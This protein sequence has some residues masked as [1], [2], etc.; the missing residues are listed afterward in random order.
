MQV[1]LLYAAEINVYEI[2]KDLKEARAFV[3][4]EGMQK[5]N[6]INEKTLYIAIEN[7][8]RCALL[9]INTAMI[10]LNPYRPNVTL[11]VNLTALFSKAFAFLRT[12]K[13]DLSVVEFCQLMEQLLK[14]SGLNSLMSKGYQFL[15]FKIVNEKLHAYRRV[16]DAS[17][18]AKEESKITMNFYL[19]YVESIFSVRD[20]PQINKDQKFVEFLLVLIKNFKEADSFEDA[21]F[22]AEKGLSL[23]PEEPLLLRE[24]IEIQTKLFIDTISKLNG[25]T[26]FATRKDE[27]N[28]CFVELK[29]KIEKNPP[30][31]PKKASNVVIDSHKKLIAQHKKLLESYHAAKKICKTDRK[32][33]VELEDFLQ[34]MKSQCSD[35]KINLLK[36]KLDQTDKNLNSYKELESH[37]KQLDDLSASFSNA[38]K[39]YEE[40]C[41]RFAEMQKPVAAQVNQSVSKSAAKS[42]RKKNKKKEKQVAAKILEAVHVVVGPEIPATKLDPAAANETAQKSV[43]AAKE[44]EQ[45]VAMEP[46]QEVPNQEAAKAPD[47]KTPKTPASTKKLESNFSEKLALKLY[48]YEALHNMQIIHQCNPETDQVK[49]NEYQKIIIDC[50]QNAMQL[51]RGKSLPLDELYAVGIYAHQIDK[52]LGEIHNN[53]SKI[54]EDGI[55][56]KVSTDVERAAFYAH[57]QDYIQTIF[58]NGNIRLFDKCSYNINKPLTDNLA[59]LFRDAFERLKNSGSKSPARDIL[60][61]C[62]LMEQL[63]NTCKLMLWRHDIYKSMELEIVNNKMSIYRDWIALSKEKKVAPEVAMGHYLRYVNFIF[64]LKPCLHPNIK[65]D[66]EF[67]ECL[68]AII[69]HFNKEN[70][71]EEAQTYLKKGLILL[72]NQPD[73]MRQKIKIEFEPRLKMLVSDFAFTPNQSLYCYAVYIHL[74]NTIKDVQ[75]NKNVLMLNHLEQLFIQYFEVQFTA[76]EHLTCYLELKNFAIRGVDPGKE[77]LADIF[78]SGYFKALIKEMTREMDIHLAE[79]DKKQI[80]KYCSAIF[81]NQYVNNKVANFNDMEQKIKELVKKA[82]KPFHPVKPSAA[83]P[84]QQEPKPTHQPKARPTGQGVSGQGM[85]AQ[86]PQQQP[87]PAYINYPS[88]HQAREQ[89]FDGRDSANPKMF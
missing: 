29:Q 6:A 20:N 63:L 9:K 56:K 67:M 66:K 8:I 65:D 88:R 40:D 78:I 82:I 51:S 61:F 77:N 68:L 86:L 18:E 72:P 35:V 21:S 23:L 46:N 44:P 42:K 47:L 87:Q 17:K 28:L 45:V 38:F 69:E 34:P 80:A 60:Y 27:I 74:V 54:V 12:N 16:I 33:I 19:R 64:S 4:R 39:V 71:L 1:D 25:S 76:T 84:L 52:E 31:L 59:E 3:I 50:Y 32:I 15:E 48:E 26:D 5:K 7:Y 49:I 13:N 70:L 62:Q 37:K 22:Y 57:I 10:D 2:D 81:I 24:K 11:L 79:F 89:R 36:A 75:S 73:L 55:R 83:L 53:I 14:S 30:E 41:S 58:I 85:F 43:Q